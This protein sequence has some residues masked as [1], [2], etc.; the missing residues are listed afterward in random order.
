MSFGLTATVSR[1]FNDGGGRPPVVPLPLLSTI[2][3]PR[4][5][6]PQ[7]RRRVDQVETR[8][9][10]VKDCLNQQ[11]LPHVSRAIGALPAGV[12]RVNEIAIGVR[13]GS[14]VKPVWVWS[15]LTKGS[16]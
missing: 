15:W 10:N 5:E 3:P 14:A 2:P 8:R 4:D 1:P 16:I 11:V 9:R 13:R 6:P 12:Y 7:K